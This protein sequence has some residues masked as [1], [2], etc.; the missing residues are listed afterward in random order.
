[1]TPASEP[2]SNA[3]GNV[4]ESARRLDMYQ[5]T[6]AELDV[7]IDQCDGLTAEA[8]QYVRDLRARLAAGDV[9]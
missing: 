6:E 9:C 1:M 5:M 7:L 4:W 8:A 2:A 3:A